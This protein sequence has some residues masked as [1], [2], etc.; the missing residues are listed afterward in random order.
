MFPIHF[1]FS[2]LGKELYFY[3]GLY[4][5]IA[6]ISGYLIA[7]KNLKHTGLSGDDFTTLLLIA[8]CSG[9]L[10]GRVYHQLFYED[11]QG[12][13]NI[14]RIFQVWTGGL[15]ITG[16]VII[17]PML[18]YLYCRIKKFNYWKLFALVV[19]AV[20]LAQTV[21]RAGCFLNGD[22]HGTKTESVFG[23]QFPRYGILLNTGEKL[24]DPRR[25]S[26]AWLYSFD[27]GW[28]DENSV[29]SAPLHP[30]Q[31]YEA[32]ADLLLFLL[33]S[34]LLKRIIAENLDHKI[35][36]LVYVGGYSIIRFLLEFSRADRLMAEGNIFSAMQITLL[37]SGFVGLCLAWRFWT[38]AKGKS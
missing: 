25:S 11:W 14:K 18:T 38:Q 15:S 35:V 3:E 5:A 12:I 21:G 2:F 17:G 20:I 31:L 13:E 29:L 8:L 37:I 28:V 36:P 7:R 27:H 34:Y 9:I 24:T 23:M 30:S 16:A 6:I 22:A 4:F 32:V 19:P 1:Y 10:G 33:V 26:D